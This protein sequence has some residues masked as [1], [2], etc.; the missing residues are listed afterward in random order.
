MPRKRQSN[1]IR[2]RNKRARM[3]KF[4]AGRAAPA[5]RIHRS[6]VLKHSFPPTMRVKLECSQ[7]INIGTQAAP[8]ALPYY[9]SFAAN[10]LFGNGAIVNSA[11]ATNIVP[12]G[13]IYL[14]GSPSL[15]GNAFANGAPYSQYRILGCNMRTKFALMPNVN[16]V[17]PNV[18]VAS[19]PNTLPIQANGLV[20]NIIEQP[21]NKWTLVKQ[22]HG[23][24]VTFNHNMT[25]SRIYA[26]KGEVRSN[27]Y[28][29]AIAA[30]VISLPTS[31]WYHNYT[32]LAASTSTLATFI[33][34][35]VVQLDYD[36]EF[37]NRNEMSSANPV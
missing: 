12:A 3:S 9:I 17:Q 33:A 2:R 7:L 30:G 31:L 8:A 32:I 29:G 36:V 5:A 23:A 19:T 11:A 14:L 10:A 24:S 28:A 15:G 4:Y 20:T 26:L 13:L 37:F 16:F 1:L 21:N 25:T 27:E 34:G 35:L 6:I 18:V 22:D